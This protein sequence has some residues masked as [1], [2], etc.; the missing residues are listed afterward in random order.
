ML[1]NKCDFEGCFLTVDVE[2]CLRDHLTFLTCFD[3]SFSKF[4][5]GILMLR[6]V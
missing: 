4:A 5:L 1:Q 2:G 3:D 6:V